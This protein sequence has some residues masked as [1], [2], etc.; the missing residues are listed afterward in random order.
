MNN[1]FKIIV[2]TL[3]SGFTFSQEQEK[4]MPA[5]DILKKYQNVRDFTISKNQDEIYFTIQ[6]P[7]E[8]RAVIAVIKKKK[9]RWSEPEMTSFSGNYRNIEPF[10]TQDG[11]RLYFASNRPINDTITKVKDYDIWYVERKDLKSKWSKPINVGTPVNS[12][13]NEFYPCV[14]LNGNL[15]FTSD[16]I[17]TLGKDDIL[18]CKWD[19][20]Q[21][22]EPENLGMNINST[23][24]EFN[25]FV[26]PSEDFII[27][28]CYGRPD[29]LG[30]GDLYISYKNNKGN[31]DTAK[32]LGE[33]INSKQM[34]YCPFYDTTTQTLYF[35]SKRM[36]VIDTTFT[37]LKEFET[38]I[39]SYENGFS[40][41]Y[42]YQIKL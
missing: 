38:E 23:G 29:G 30:S 26:S 7:S 10:L 33:T 25:A 31:W 19:G 1:F 41:I 20:K 32:N 2:I 9:K 28:T 13:N 40:R 35:T 42:K 6:N 17:K 37:N 14:T 39:S 16:A 5:I 36:I 15:Y 34:D 27:Y 4:P 21:Y 22:T 12:T 24:Y 18:V 3:I 8:E 11:L